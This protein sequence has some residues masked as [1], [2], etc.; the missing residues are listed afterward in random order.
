LRPAAGRR[1]ADRHA[2]GQ[3]V[4]LPGDDAVLPGGTGVR[5]GRDDHRAVHGGL[6]G[7]P[8]GLPGEAQAGLQG[9]L[10][11][12]HADTASDSLAVISPLSHCSLT[13]LAEHGVLST[14]RNSM[15]LR[16]RRF[17]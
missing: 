13:R 14:V 1:T 4:G 15:A 12:G 7:G 10:T 16:T 9:P 3:A 2:T 5:A 11:T 8:A 17:L 6:Q